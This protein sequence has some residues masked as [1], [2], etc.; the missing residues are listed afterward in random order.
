MCG[1]SGARCS[2]KPIFCDMHIEKIDMKPTNIDPRF[3]KKYT[4]SK[5]GARV[6]GEDWVSSVVGKKAKPK[7][8]DWIKAS[9]ANKKPRVKKGTKSTAGLPEIIII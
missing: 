5:H 9:G 2:S 4:V 1:Y 7:G 8:T 6:M 3:S